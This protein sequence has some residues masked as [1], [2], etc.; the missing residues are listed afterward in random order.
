MDPG[1]ISYQREHHLVAA[2]YIACVGR[3]TLG[4]GRPLSNSQRVQTMLDGANFIVTARDENGALIGLA[5]CMNDGAWICFCADLA[6]RDSHQGQG[7]GRAIIEKCRE[8]LGPSI[9]FILASE[10]S[11]ETFYERAGMKRYAA[12]FHPRIDVS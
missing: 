11:A 1:P 3:T 6:V 12:F 4:A 9:G 2:E 5:R 7:V 10:P 8:L